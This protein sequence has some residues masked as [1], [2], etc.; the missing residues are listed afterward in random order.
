[1]GVK[2]ISRSTEEMIIRTPNGE[3]TFKIVY[4]FPFS[5]ERKRM[6]IILKSKLIEGY[7]FYLKGAD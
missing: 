2:L 6:G 1:L 5:S 7:F 4:E 3:E